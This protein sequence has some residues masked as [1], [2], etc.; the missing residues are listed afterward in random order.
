MGE[1]GIKGSKR[2]WRSHKGYR[3]RNGSIVAHHA[4]KAKAERFAY[5]KGEKKKNNKRSGDAG[6]QFGQEG[7]SE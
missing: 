5:E 2:T 3:K 1:G 7:A 6:P 4:N